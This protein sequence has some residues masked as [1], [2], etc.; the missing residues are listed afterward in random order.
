MKRIL[1]LADINSTHTR[2]W[3]ESLAEKGFDIGIFSLSSPQNKW[4]S[5]YKNIHVLSGSNISVKTFHKSSV[6]KFIY[7]K[8]MPN[9]KKAIRA[10][11]PDILH[12][13]YATSYGLLGRMSGFH[14]FI[15]SCW[16]SDV[17]DFPSKS[18]FHRL[19]LKNI[20]SKADKILATSNTI[21]KYI[22]EIVRKE[23]V[24]T[25][26]GVDT[27]IFKPLQ[28]KL[29]KENDIVIGTI[30][31]LEKNYCIDVLIEA[32]AIIKGDYGNIKLLVVG[33]GTQRKELELLAEQENIKADE[34]Y[35]KGKVDHAEVCNYHNM[36]DIFVNISEYESFGVSVLEAMACEKP[37]IVTD[38][39]GLAEIVNDES[40][41]LK[42]P[43][44]D[45][46]ALVSKL[47]YLIENRDTRENMGRQARKLVQEKYEWNEN[48]LQM[49]S[50]YNSL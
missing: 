34:I 36:I 50:I 31:S 39:G 22:H 11:R 19:T 8:Y 5:E 4:F 37:V 17:M 16:G 30:K 42:I 29:F 15:I 40:V 2:K 47:R 38:T 25:P 1:F 20:L 44:R 26:F 48:V 7:L 28:N 45:V 14:P 13:H 49:I 6:G 32:F 35:F 9:I 43:V 12:A 23:V 10:F 3:V 27:D 24:I 46:D 18:F 21:E 33:D 41:G